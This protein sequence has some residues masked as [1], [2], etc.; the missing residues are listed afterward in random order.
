[1]TKQYHQHFIKVSGP[2][3]EFGMEHQNPNKY[4]RFAQAMV[5]S[6]PA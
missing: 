3:A 2:S 5:Q 1:M 4:H 6:S